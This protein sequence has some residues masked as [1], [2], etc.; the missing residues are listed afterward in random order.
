MVSL[1]T[2]VSLIP[3][4]KDK[5]NPCRNELVQDIAVVEDLKLSPTA[6]MKCKYEWDQ[7]PVDSVAPW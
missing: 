4:T 1:K 5:Q 6:R 7:R 2:N 3:S